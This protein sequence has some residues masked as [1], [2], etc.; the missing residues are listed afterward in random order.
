MRKVSLAVM[1]FCLLT[2]GCTTMPRK[3]V[4]RSDLPDD[5]LFSESPFTVKVTSD[6]QYF[7]TFAAYDPYSNPFVNA[8]LI[9]REA[10][11]IGMYTIVPKVG[12]NVK[13]IDYLMNPTGYS[14]QTFYVAELSGELFLF[15]PEDSVNQQLAQLSR[16]QNSSK[17]VQDQASAEAAKPAENV[18]LFLKGSSGDLLIAVD[19]ANM[20]GN[21][22]ALRMHILFTNSG[23]NDLRVSVNDEL[24]IHTGGGNLGLAELD[25]VPIIPANSI[26]PGYFTLYLPNAV[27]F[28]LGLSM[29]S[30]QAVEFKQDPQKLKDY[31]TQLGIDGIYTLHTTGE[32][33]PLTL[34]FE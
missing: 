15:A 2:L 32:R 24:V 26:A 9:N 18:H 3:Y 1:G 34:S 16:Q 4:S 11:I 14:S 31:G 20:S 23:K 8:D 27:G 12:T 25:I 22:T 5:V 19:L 6:W 33:I 10:I 17:Q 29:L 7:P 13:P 21:S 28:T 30:K